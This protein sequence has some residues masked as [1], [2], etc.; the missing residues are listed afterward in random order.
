MNR[1]L[2]F[3]VLC[4]AYGLAQLHWNNVDSL[5]QPLPAG[6]H[7]YFTDDAI[8]GKPNRA[9]YVSADLNQRSLEFVTDTTLNRRL[10]PS[11]FYTKNARPLL[12]VNSSF[13]EFVHNRN[14]NVVINRGRLLAY[15]TP[16]AGRG[17]DTL[18]YTHPLVSA[19][20]I[21][22]K[23]TA[24]VAWTFT[25]SSKRR[26]Y[27]V[28]EIY[29]PI[30]DANQVLRLRN[31]GYQ[32]SDAQ[33]QKAAKLKKWKMQTAVGGGPVLLQNGNVAITNNEELKFAGKGIEDKHPRTGMGYTAGGRLI[34]MVVEGRAPGIAEGVTLV[35]EA[36]L[37]KD[38][39]CAEA[40]NLDGGGSSCMLVN[41]KETIRPS[42]KE[43]QRP[44]PAVFMI[45]AK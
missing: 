19:L 23:R 1:L 22:K 37:F 35:Q 40:L 17:K 32:S 21:S 10:T 44:V 3:L 4:P 8:E 45:K 6:V 9:F 16:I 2:V 26:A 25:D 38:L 20:G 24:D 7:V 15:N 42:D 41:G 14:L 43:G 36:Q 28:Q 12:V 33:Q 31:A 5:Y 27:A 29:P 13:F 18:T 34:I 39:G 11:S 30:K